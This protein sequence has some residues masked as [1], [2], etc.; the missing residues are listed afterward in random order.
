MAP[1]VG[2][3]QRDEEPYAY[4]AKSWLME[5]VVGEKA[6][7]LVEYEIN[8]REQGTLF[9]KGKNVNVE[10]AKTG[11]VKLN[12]K[13]KVDAPASKHYADIEKAIEDAKKNQL[14]MY[15]DGA[16]HGKHKRKLVYSNTDDFSS[17]E[18]LKKASKVKKPFKGVVEY[19][20]SPNAVNVYIE[21]LS[22]VTRIGLNHI[23]TPA[24]ERATSIEAKEFVEKLL[25]NR[26]VGVS[27]QRIDD[28]GNLVGRIHHK[29]G[30][31]DVELV[32]RGLSKVLIP[33]D[34]SYEKGHY[35]KIRD[36]Q[37]IAQI[38]QVGM[39]K[40]LEKS[41]ESK[42]TKSYDPKL[43]N[44]DA[45]IVEVHSGDSISVASEGGEPRRIFLA[46]IKAPKMS[47]RDSD[48]H[49]PWAWESKEF[50]R[51]QA[52]GKKV[53]VEM[54]FNREIE[55]KSGA[56]EGNKRL[57]EFATVFIGK[58]NLAVSVL[59]KGFAKTQLSKFKEE[60]S[61]YFEDLIAASTKA[62]NKKAGIHSN[63]E[64]NIIRQLDT[65]KN[66]K[67]AKNI[68]STLTGKNEI[69]GVVEFCF[70]GQKLKIRLDSE[71]CSI[72]FGLIGIKI[73]QPDANQPGITEVSELAKDYVKSNY[74][75]RDV[76]INVKYMDKRGTF[77]GNMWMAGSGKARLGENLAQVLL[78]KGYGNIQDHNA[79]KLGKI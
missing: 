61:K 41:E 13:R 34:D 50:V 29:N 52:I 51:K 70:S 14:G 67:S 69:S 62:S 17:D 49:E 16:D 20:F 4:D 28:H 36:A 38:H 73:P 31:I 57:M 39:W 72:A 60:N 79:D 64:A 55:I 19:V 35:K 1:K 6:E 3:P 42:K 21:T 46:S 63:K 24:Q 74:H 48:D 44:V 75:Q 26:V 18:V 56:N 2:T 37:D 59:E 15:N 78:R 68:Y 23:F 5:K 11:F 65:S 10:L 76:V 32:K 71:N 7:F 45:K 54:E 27:I 22:I 77:L 9:V 66:S 58:N 30:D 47:N 25:L 43:K 12:E 53:K 40:N 33:Q 8:G